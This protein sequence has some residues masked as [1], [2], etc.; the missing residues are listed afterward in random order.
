MRILVLAILLAVSVSVP[1]AVLDLESFDYA[2]CLRW[3]M[4][5]DTGGPISS[6]VLSYSNALARR[7][8]SQDI[9]S[10][11]AKNGDSY[12][13]KFGVC[14]YENLGEKTVFQC[15]PNQ[16]YPFSG[17]TFEYAV[18]Q[19]YRHVSVLSCTKGCAKNV[20]T[21]IYE[22]SQDIPD[23]EDAFEAER[24]RRESKF[25]KLCRKK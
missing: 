25:V 22:L 20:P 14:T 18:S 12:I 10:A 4:S 5:S 1:A 21:T 2:K 6:S 15:L 19:P 13:E 3:S 16:D 8:P 17:A 9:F 23:D 24:K 11:T 7:K